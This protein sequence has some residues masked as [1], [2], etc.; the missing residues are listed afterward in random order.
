MMKPAPSVVEIRLKSG[1]PNLRVVA[2]DP[3]NSRGTVLRAATP[4]LE[5][6]LMVEHG[7]ARRSD[8]LSSTSSMQRNAQCDARHGCATRASAFRRAAGAA[9]IGASSDQVDTVDAVDTVGP[10]DTA[11][12]VDVVAARG[13]TFEVGTP[14]AQPDPAV[15]SRIVGHLYE[16]AYH[17]VYGFVRRSVG[18]EAAEEISH[19]VFIRLLKVRNLERMTI[20]VAY[21]LRIAENLLKR[22]FERAQRYR[23][24]LERSG[25]V[26]SEHTED[27]EQ[28]QGWCLGGSSQAGVACDAGRLE[29]VLRHLTS[30]EQTAIRLIVC[31]GLD[32]QAAARSLGV[33][34]S[35]I[36]NWKHR[37]LA[38]L[39][40]LIEQQSSHRGKF[41]VA[42]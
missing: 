11:D 18:E 2:T 28:S 38:K 4:P 33:P 42:S 34:V 16:T 21:L 39:R 14:I 30:E 12:T 24:I 5:W 41:A 36:N 10:V 17:R 23:V 6:P 3:G 26:V 25:M 31:E 13:D 15:R 27:R 9:T 1:A 35:T 32:Y 7:T 22:R 37:G 20:S 40:L 19:E 8:E 29:S